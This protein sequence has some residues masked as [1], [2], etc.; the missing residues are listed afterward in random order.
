MELIPPIQKWLKDIFGTKDLGPELTQTLAAKTGLDTINIDGK[1]EPLP[2][3]LDLSGKELSFY[4]SWLE[5][6]KTE[7]ESRLLR[8]KTYDIMDQNSSDVQ[9]MLDTFRD[10]ALSVGFVEEPVE[11][12]ITGSSK[13]KTD[14]LTVL[15]ENKVLENKLGDIRSIAKY[16]DMYK[17]L[18]IEGDP[19]KPTIQIANMSQYEVEV[20]YLKEIKKKLGYII[21]RMKKD[22][23]SAKAVVR[24]PGVDTRY[25]LQPWEI[26]QFNIPDNQYEPY[27][28]S[29]LEAVR[30][31]FDQLVTM[32]AL[33]AVTRANR[34]ER[35]IV[36]IPTNATNPTNA[37]K[38]LQEVR[39]FFKSVILGQPM[40]GR[41]T[42]NK[43]IGLTDMIW[44]PADE[45]YELDKI[46]SSIDVSSDE[47]VRYFLE[48]FIAASRLPKG[49]FLSDQATDRGSM[50]SSQDLKFARALLPLQKAYTEGL[51]MM[52]TYIG[53]ILGH[54][55]FDVQVN[56]FKPPQ[57]NREQ[58]E[59]YAAQI[60]V[61][62][63]LIGAFKSAA[64]EQD[65]NAGVAVN[66]TPDTFV[67][68]LEK[69]GIPEP[70]LDVLRNAEMVQQMPTE[71]VKETVKKVLE[72][73]ARAIAVSSRASEM[74][75]KSHLKV[76]R[77]SY[78]SSF[79]KL[80][81]QSKKS[82]KVEVTTS[83][84]EKK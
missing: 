9:L 83:I 69:L 44:M 37:F 50:L 1:E 43:D 45:G 67:T 65:P 33:Y 10:E 15:A 11:I 27:G 55:N 79:T 74:F 39:S 3:G 24:Q 26:V 14:I 21:D 18:I 8:Y 59:M 46:A 13:A 77:E 71:S 7:D 84:V 47:D 81:K 16:G 40:T 58:V 76:L 66:V 53:T 41:S 38:K 31:P 68:V 36:K 72:S 12:N 2:P 63:S 35:L 49:F 48:K 34:V 61:A 22:A 60:N 19:A 42:I 57:I 75:T 5:T 52:C 23:A 73:P 25:R 28:R 6:Y 4:K 20:T 70:I 51:T 54:D 17:R 64:F 56:L 29:I 78:V 62:Q 30:V 80:Q 32:E 82:S